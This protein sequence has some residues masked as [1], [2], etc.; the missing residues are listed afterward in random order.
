M[1]NVIQ[2]TRIRFFMIALSVVVIAAGIT[3][4]VM[5]DGFNLGIDFEAGLRQR[6][7][8]AETAGDV[9]AVAVRE[10]LSGI[11][12]VQVQTVGAPEER[13]FSIRVR[14]PGDVENFSE[15]M[16]ERVEEDLE[17]A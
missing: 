14:D 17:E 10:A 12:G 15:V 8:I 16:S 6:V 1:K 3:A 13:Q 4:T 7:E 5:N 11:E 9:D 2:F